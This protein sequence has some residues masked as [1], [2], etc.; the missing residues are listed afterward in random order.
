MIA[1]DNDLVRNTVTDYLLAQGCLVIPA[2]NGTEAIELTR[3]RRPDVILMDIQMP[4]MDG[5]EAIRRIRDEKDSRAVAIIAV[6][7]LA[8]AGDRERCLNAGADFYM[9]KPFRLDSLRDVILS[10]GGGNG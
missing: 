8:M 4:V 2:Q 5:I 7:A 1:E 9:T 3:E 10:L 6:T